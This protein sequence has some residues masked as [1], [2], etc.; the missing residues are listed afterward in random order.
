M[1][2][3]LD[4]SDPLAAFRDR[5]LIPD[6]VIY[7]NGNSLGPLSR[8]AKERMDEVVN[9]EWGN[10][11]IRGWNSAGWYEL[12]WRLGDKIGRLIGAASG[13]TVVCDSTSVN[14]FKAVAAAFAMRPGRNKIVT[15]AGNFPT[16]LYILDGL[17]RFVGE[18][19]VVDIRPRE[20]VAD[21]IDSETAVVVLTHVHY[22]SGALFPMADITAK[23]HAAGDAAQRCRRRLRCW[24]RLQT[25][26]RRP[27][28]A[29]IHLRRET[30]SR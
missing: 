10:E 15:E 30:P 26:Q 8:D 12:P 4:A 2:V 18:D 7:M 24:L 14:L 1:V 19:C 9:N 29:S 25:S 21:A 27:G 22:V 16:D 6:G 13:E 11:L 3:D 23:A 17:R 28:C 5:F 20:E